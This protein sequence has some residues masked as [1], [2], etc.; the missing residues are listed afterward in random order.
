MITMSGVTVPARKRRRPALSCIE[1]RRRKI[2]C[3]RNMPCNH[4]IQSK[5]AVCSYKDLHP[6]AHSR[7]ARTTEKT[8][9]TPLSANDY[10]GD[11]DLAAVPCPRRCPNLGVTDD[12]LFDVNS[13][14][15]SVPSLTDGS[16]S[17]REPGISPSVYHTAASPPENND[18]DGSGNPARRSG[19]LSTI[20]CVAFGSPQAIRESDDS[21]SMMG[22]NFSTF[23]DL[24]IQDGDGRNTL[25]TK[26]FKNTNSTPINDYKGTLC[27][28]RYF[29][30]SHW[31]FV[32]K[33]VCQ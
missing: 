16:Q 6:S 12:H 23:E 29:G 2:K 10:L 14:P 22:I 3:D 31:M 18:P 7:T 19:D 5:N 30:Q 1:C 13:L 27:K 20:S 9:P 21:M 11:L 8:A 28:T 4:C 15:R 17:E 33:Q 24:M 25:R 26:V 32:L